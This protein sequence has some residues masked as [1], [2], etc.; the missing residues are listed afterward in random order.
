[1][2]QEVPCEGQRI[3]SLEAAIECILIIIFFFKKRKTLALALLCAVCLL[4]DVVWGRGKKK[5]VYR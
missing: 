1:V 4:C 5:G 2:G 3:G